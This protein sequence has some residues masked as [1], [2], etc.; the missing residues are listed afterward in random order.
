MPLES[1]CTCYHHQTPFFFFF[2]QAM[3]DVEFSVCGPC[4]HVFMHAE[5]VKV[6]RVRNEHMKK[7]SFHAEATPRYVVYLQNQMKVRDN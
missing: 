6:H 5:S 4:Q 2:V 3:F 7:N 1:L